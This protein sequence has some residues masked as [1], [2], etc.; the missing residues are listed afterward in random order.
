MKVSGFTFVKN[1]MILG[2]PFLES[3]KSILPICDEFVVNVG[4]SED[5]TLEMVRSIDD[6]KIQIIESIWNDKMRVAGYVY[7]Q[8]KMIAQFSCTGD[9]AFYL[10]ADE[11]VHENDLAQIKDS[12]FSY[13][14]DDEVEALIFDYIHFYGNA[15][16]YMWSPAAYRRAPRVIKTSIRSYAPDGLFWLVLKKNKIGRYPRAAHTGAT[17]YHYGWVRTEE[18]M[19][20]KSSKVQQYWNKEHKEIQYSEIAPFIL[21]DFEGKHPGVIQDWI[22]K[23]KGRFQAN[24]KHRLTR[25]EWKHRFMLKLEAWFGL[26]LSKKHFKLV[27]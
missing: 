1:G 22:P 2:Y 15:N 18:Q 8:Q 10:E 6:P 23:E 17:I 4:Q 5:D 11:V 19:N 7:G 25:R 24:P 3:I 20:L 13:L 16:T 14:H 12:M 27:K 26:Q 9:W 21:R